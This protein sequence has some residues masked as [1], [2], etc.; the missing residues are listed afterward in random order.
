[1]DSENIGTIEVFIRAYE[2]RGDGINAY[3]V[4]KIE[5]RVNIYKFE[6]CFFFLILNYKF[7]FRF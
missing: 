7:F 4:Y 2:K 6:L 3:L 1:M 5:T